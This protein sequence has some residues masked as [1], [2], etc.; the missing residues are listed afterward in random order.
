MHN[1][2]FSDPV[3]DSSLFTSRLAITLLGVLLLSLIIIFR[4]A[5]LQVSQHQDFV[6][7]SD[8]NRV[9]VRPSPPSRGL[10]YDRNGELLA[11][12]RP[13]YSLNIVR[14][15]AD[16]LDE[17]IQSLGLLID[18]SE[19]DIKRFRKR[20]GRRRPYE[21][22]PLKFNLTEE[23]RSILAVNSYRLNGAEISARL[24][25]FYPYR[26]LFGHV[27]G[28]VGRIND[29]EIVEIDP[30]QY[31]GTDS[32]GKIG[33][34]KY[35]EEKL[36]GQVG[37]EHVETNARGRVMR[38]LEKVDAIS[39]SDLTLH[40]D[41]RIQQAAYGALEG[42]RGAL[43]AIDVKTGGVLAM[44][45]TPSFDPNLFVTGISQK[46]YNNLLYSPDR[47]L[48]DRTVR[49]QYPPGSTVKPVY[50]LISL[51]KNTTT[52]DYTVRDTGYYHLPGIERPWRDWK[53]GGHGYRVDLA[54]AIIESCDIYFY[55]I[56]YKT[57]I[58]ELSRYSHLFGLG[59][60]TGVDLPGERP[61]IMPS[62][63]WKKGSRGQSW[64]NGDTINASIGQG[65]M[66]ATPLQ[67]AV[68]AARVASRG[69][70]RKPRLLKAVNGVDLPH[71]EP[72]ATIKIQSKYWDYV[73]QA[74][75][76]VIHSP[77]GT[78]Q[79]IHKGLTYQ[80]AGKTGTA[81]VIS[82]KAEEEYDS[83][84]LDKRQWDHALFVAFA[85]ADDPQIA[86]GLIVENGEHGSSAAAPVARIV[87]DTY[88]ANK[89]QAAE[90]QA[91]EK[92]T[93]RQGQG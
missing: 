77:R 31:S 74:M 88:M 80:M 9:H 89:L 41:T 68:M 67:L 16:N 54:Q 87:I 12:N 60:P 76:D 93:E 44:A 28:Y 83:S 90:K 51:H 92:Q 91:K 40:L 79:G 39:G 22:T 2:T 33:L 75:I 45:S 82:V 52:M 4:Y 61:G 34:E 63:A 62:K 7:Q 69:E 23:E 55:D 50:G 81:Q 46:D 24:T 42:E 59:Y 6:T 38:V 48:F 43:V 30:V 72:E 20:L 57:G 49:G 64:F 5:D 19:A 13:S 21:Q 14:E 66:L 29:R 73:H 11:D 53:R 32:I 25:R 56:G 8:N 78:A 10:I 84:K 37:S 70:I 18:I 85:P 58:D 27:I 36:L 15:R 26:E 86:V 47:P 35:Y 71:E 65:Y 17:L 3:R 1:S